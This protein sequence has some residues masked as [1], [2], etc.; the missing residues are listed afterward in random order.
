M[1]TGAES[2]TLGFEYTDDVKTWYLDSRHY[3]PTVGNNAVPSNNTVFP[4]PNA[5]DLGNYGVKVNYT[6]NLENTTDENKTVIYEVRT[7]APIIVYYTVRDAQGRIIGQDSKVKI[8]TTITPEDPNTSDRDLDVEY[9][10]D[11]PFKL[12]TV[13]INKGE[14]KRLDV[15][16]ILPNASTGGWHNFM[17]AV[18]Q[19]SITE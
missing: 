13:D 17:R 19:G 8:P 6:V 7:P 1:D 3:S 2:S 10:W 15:T 14:K 4:I 12:L 11:Y 9:P 18:P 5:C 16:V